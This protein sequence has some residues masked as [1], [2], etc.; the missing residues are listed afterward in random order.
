MTQIEH[1]LAQLRLRVPREHAAVMIDPP[2]AAVVDMVSANRSAAAERADF[3]CQGRSLGELAAAASRELLRRARRYT[4]AYRDVDDAFDDS[5]GS[6]LFV[7]GHQPELFHTGVWLKNLAL[8]SLAARHGAVGV[9]L[10]IDNDAVRKTTLQVPSGSA[11]RAA[12]QAVPIDRPAAEA[13]FEARRILD[14]ELFASFGSR[15]QSVLAPLVPDSMIGTFWPAAVEAARENDNLG[16]C[17]SRA[18]HQWEARWGY[19]T[20]ELPLSHVCRTEPF[21]WLLADLFARGEQLH[22]VYNSALA[23][24][25]A[26]FRIRSRTHPVPDLAQQDGLLEMPFWIWTAQDPRRRPLFLGRKGRR[27]VIGDRAGFQ[28]ELALSHGCD[29]A[30]AVG[31]LGSLTDQGVALRPRALMTTLVA[32]TLLSD[33]FI[34]GI[35]GAKYDQLTDL[36]IS[37]LFCCSPPQFLVVT[38]TALLDIPHERVQIEDIRRVDR[39]AR[40]LT[41]D[42]E[43]HLDALSEGGSESAEIAQVVETKRF[44]IAQQP[45]RGQRLRR[46]R[47]IT[48]ANRQLQPFVARKRARL[49]AE[50]AR[51]VECWRNHRILGSREYAFCLFSEPALRDWCLDLFPPTS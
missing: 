38:G 44:W 26:A 19:Q 20:L 5:A 14:R 32:R 51:L 7:S 10:L 4:T 18:R 15:V 16:Y 3:D 22:E 43:R 1:K 8:G 2:L 23:E 9:H 41:F 28:T 48:K 12:V 47:E 37:R 42:P 6:L 27:T 17:V 50:R 11:Q 39:L 30:A 29:A 25:R 36:L 21:L 24:Y 40:E 13:P 45:P 33:L 35:G 31:Q 46:H 34:H 49:A